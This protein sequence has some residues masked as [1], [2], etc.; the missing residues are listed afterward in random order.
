ML[1]RSHAYV[2]IRR[3]VSVLKAIKSLS[4]TVKACTQLVLRNMG[5]HICTG[6]LYMTLHYYAND[7]ISLY[8]NICK[9]ELYID[10]SFNEN[11]VS[12]KIF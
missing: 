10:T 11:P 2:A 6:K 12:F 1:F 8:I 3:Q 4:S 9:F 5:S 7:Y